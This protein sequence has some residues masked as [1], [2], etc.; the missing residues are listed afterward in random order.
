MARTNVTI[1]DA[2]GRAGISD[3]QHMTDA[4]LDAATAP[5]GKVTVPID[6]PE[7]DLDN[8][9]ELPDADHIDHEVEAARGTVPVKTLHV[10]AQEKYN[11]DHQLVSIRIRRN[12]VRTKIG[13]TWYT[14]K[15]GEEREVQRWVADWLQEQ[16]YL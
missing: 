8:L 9:P 1:A 6:A 11:L 13:D 2:K 15:K 12:L 3:P 16:G 7:V 4:E 5:A 14:F 10:D